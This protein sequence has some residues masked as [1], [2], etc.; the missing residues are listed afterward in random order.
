MFKD[1]I[2]LINNRFIEILDSYEELKEAMKYS[3][4]P[5]GKRLRPLLVLLTL[6]DLGLDLR[7][8]L[9][10]ACAIEMIHTYSLIHDDLPAMDNDEFRRGEPTSH[11]AF[12]ENVAI[13]AGDALLT[14]AFYVLSNCCLDAEKKIKIIS[15]VSKLS[16]ARGMIRGQYLD[17]KSDKPTFELVD[18]VH[19]HKTKDLI[20]SSIVSAAIIASDEK[21]QVWEQIALYLGKAFQIKD[22]LDDL[23]KIEE[24]TIVK[25]VGLDEANRLFLEYRF[26][27]LNLIEEKLGKKDMF[28]LVEMVI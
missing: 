23:E 15:L 22:D 7:I 24:M 28:H 13:L 14:E 26:K 6:K 20:E 18:L 27:C 1:E 2:N 11:I 3:L 9:D 21:D 16:G 10:V 5:G 4:I 19:T 17:L 8:G 25:A 12:G